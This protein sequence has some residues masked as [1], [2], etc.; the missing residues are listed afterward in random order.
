MEKYLFNDGTNGVREVRS[1]EELDKLIQSAENIAA[2][3]IWVF[4]TS[5]WLNYNDFKKL[6]ALAVIPARKR[7]PP[8]ANLPAAPVRSYKW[9][10]RL[11]LLVVVIGVAALGYIFTRE[12]WV[13]LAPVSIQASVPENMPVLDIDS[14]IAVIE[15]PRKKALDEVT[16]TNLR[17]RNSWPD[18]VRAQVFAQRDSSGRTILFNNL[19]LSIDNATG[20]KIDE[21]VIRLEVWKGGAISREESFAF[22][23]VGYD[24]L[25]KRDIN[26]SYKGDSLL[27][28]YE[29]VRSKAFNFCYEEKKKSTSGNMNDRW[30]C[31]D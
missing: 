18:R 17:I 13:K 14:L 10:K 11:L 30:F 28:V 22:K 26:R 6:Y 16:R 9:I 25:T 1:K 7:V 27:M 20:Y 19:Q 8:S 24:A 15:K 3:R 4:N 5:E 12:K 2:V 29:K 23:N 31:R 21:V